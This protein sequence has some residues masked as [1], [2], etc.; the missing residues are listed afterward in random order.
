M[1]NEPKNLDARPVFR[2]LAGIT[3]PVFLVMAVFL[4]FPSLGF[5][6]KPELLLAGLFLW[7]AFFFGSVATK[8]RFDYLSRQSIQSQLAIAAKKYAAGEITLDEYGSQ[9]KLIMDREEKR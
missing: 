8:G 6:E 2:W 1:A 7:S 4:V 9:S 3:C 5:T